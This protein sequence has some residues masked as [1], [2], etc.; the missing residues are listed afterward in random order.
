[1]GHHSGQAAAQQA[2]GFGNGVLVESRRGV[3]AVSVGR[4][5][6]V[7]P[8]LRPSRLQGGG[9][10][11]R[12]SGEIEAAA[13]PGKGVV[14]Q[15]GE[16]LAGCFCRQRMA[17]VVPCARRRSGR[18]ADGELHEPVRAAKLVSAVAVQ[19]EHPGERTRRAGRSDQPAGCPWPESQLPA[20]LGGGDAV[21]RFFP[22]VRHLGGRGCA[23]NSQRIRKFLCSRGGGHVSG[24]LVDVG[25]PVL[26]TGDGAGPCFLAGCAGTIAHRP[27]SCPGVLVPLAEP[28][29][30]RAVQIDFGDAVKVRSQ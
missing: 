26:V 12:G 9:G 19:R 14:G 2:C 13:S 24:M 8:P 22:V 15:D 3:V 11:P 7:L 16:T 28:C 27:A 1:M 23:G 18:V 29:A 10:P 4:Y 30:G 5:D 17:V 25:R 6:A 21:V 20:E